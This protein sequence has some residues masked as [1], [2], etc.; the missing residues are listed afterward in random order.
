[1]VTVDPFLIED[2]DFYRHWHSHSEEFAGGD[3]LATAL[4]TG[5]EIADTVA[6]DVFW[7]SGS[8]QVP[9]YYFRLNRADDTVL[10]PVLANPFVARLILERGLIVVTPEQP[11][12][13]LL[14]AIN[15]ALTPLVT[16]AEVTPE[17]EPVPVVVR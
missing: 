4:V 10:M 9:V 8:R 6:M 13:F 5:W 1:M 12:S 14:N 17:P 11:R 16:K 7:C 2:V 15:P 3:S